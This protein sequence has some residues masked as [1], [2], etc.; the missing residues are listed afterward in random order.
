MH[1]AINAHLIGT[2]SGYR[3][4]GISRYIADLCPM[5]WSAPDVERWTVYTPPGL[6]PESLNPPANVRIIRSH[7][8][9]SNP[10]ARIGWEQCIAPG[11]LLRDRPDVL[12]C[13]LNVMPLMAPCPV[14]LTL[15][16]LAFMRLKTHLWSRRSYLSTMT[17]RSV[18]RAAHV[19]AISD[20]TRSEA[21]E[22]LDVNPHNIT[23]I[24]NGCDD[25][26]TLPER[27]GV[28][29]LRTKKNLPE[30]FILYVGTLEPRK[31]LVG[32]IRAY[33]KVREKL[34]I[35]LVV[36]GG[37]GWKFSPIFEVVKELGLEDHVRFEGF[38]ESSQ[39]PLYYAAA[40]FVVYPS[41]YEGFGLPPLEAMNAGTPVIT[42]NVS[43]MPEVV[44]DAALL[45]DPYDVAEL[46]QAMVRLASD[47]VLHA[48]LRAA[49]LVQ[50]RR[51]TWEQT[52]RAVLDILRSNV[53][54]KPRSSASRL[55]APDAKSVNA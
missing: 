30:K 7:L 31:N 10:V 39:L 25:T 27:S 28:E 52:G 47:P 55:P 44:G 40:H 2:T 51:F 23:T 16:D 15:H 6:E 19:I 33:A 42:S 46:G 11:I 36:V 9:T 53:R 5:L 20:F 34:N 3:K 37:R 49:G 26:F 41:L 43:S 12:F 38:V 35:P 50:A 21:L 24:L 22:L 54:R 17:R 1:I 48:R 14:V 18:H 32:L 45:V 8:P 13:P 4:A 29:E